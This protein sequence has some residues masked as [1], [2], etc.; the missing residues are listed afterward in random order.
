MICVTKM[1]CYMLTKS[2]NVLTLQQSG[3]IGYNHI[4]SDKG[5]LMVSSTVHHYILVW[6]VWKLYLK[7]CCSFWCASVFLPFWG[8]RNIKRKDTRE[9][10]FRCLFKLS[11]MLL[12]DVKELPFRL[13]PFFY[14]RLVSV[15]NGVPE[16]LFKNDRLAQFYFG[17]LLMSI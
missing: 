4:W 3:S 8:G 10:Y 7:I 17:T 14:K 11:I 15:K 13:E 6:A 2:C 5:A 1:I 16:L 12:R 9:S